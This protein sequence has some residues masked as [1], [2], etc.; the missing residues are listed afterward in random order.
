MNCMHKLEL[1]ECYMKNFLIILSAM[2]FVL[3]TFAENFFDVEWEEF[4]PKRYQNV[5]TD[6]WHFT[7]QGRYWADRKKMFEKRMA[8]C[9]SLPEESQGAC[10]DKLRELETRAT[11]THSNETRNKALKYMMING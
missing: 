10:F 2:L 5:N 11:E 7:S 9:N 1:R 4:C 8:K 3:P 6:R